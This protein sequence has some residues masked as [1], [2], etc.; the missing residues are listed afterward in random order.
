MIVGVWLLVLG[1][2]R[3]LF[4]GAGDDDDRVGKGGT[5]KVAAMRRDAYL[6]ANKEG[7]G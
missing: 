5:A 1:Q 2:G 3:G 6:D 7:V 4:L